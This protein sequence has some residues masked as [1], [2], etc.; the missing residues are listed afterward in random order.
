MNKEIKY[1]RYLAKIALKYSGK[2]DYDMSELKSDLMAL[3]DGR[4]HLEGL[5]ESVEGIIDRRIGEIIHNMMIRQKNLESNYES[6]IQ[7]K[8][9]SPVHAPSFE[10]PKGAKEYSIAELQKICGYKSGQTLYNRI[11]NYNLKLNKRKE[12]LKVFW[13]ISAEDLEKL[14][15]G[16]SKLEESADATNSKGYQSAKDVVK[17]LDISYNTFLRKLKECKLKPGIK[18]EGRTIL[19][20]LTKK[21]KEKLSHDDRQP[22]PS[23]NLKKKKTLK[24][25]Q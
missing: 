11:N 17:E 6:L 21:D 4:K 23:S 15:H 5:V 14:K 22:M 25:K 1:F 13:Q 20:L 24:K 12:G 16:K 9:K 2:P 8:T 7:Q 18:K 3:K 10:P 19:Y